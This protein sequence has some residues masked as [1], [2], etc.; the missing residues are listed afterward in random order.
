M[1]DN[2]HDRININSHSDITFTY[3][4]DHP[5]RGER[6]FID[7]IINAKFLD[8]HGIGISRHDELGKSVRATIVNMNESPSV[9]VGLSDTT[10]EAVMKCFIKS[11][12]AKTNFTINIPKLETD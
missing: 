9:H 3:G 4:E 12:T 11:K 1:P 10:A 7:Q 8:K 5:D 6:L 2:F